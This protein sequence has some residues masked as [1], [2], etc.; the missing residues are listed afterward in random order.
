M[1][2]SV[3]TRT[4]LSTTW[5]NPPSTVKRCS[6]PP[7]PIRSVP[8]PNSVI[9][10]AWPVRMPTSPSNAGATNE[11][12]VPSNNTAS[13]E[14][15]V[16]F[17]ILPRSALCESLRVLGHVLDRAG[18]EKRLLRQIVEFARDQPLERRD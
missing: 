4:W 7:P 3:T 16:T 9:I 14:I 8:L 6:P 2:L 10:G 15:T 11:S 17:S 18:H 5:R 13:G 12:V 1:T